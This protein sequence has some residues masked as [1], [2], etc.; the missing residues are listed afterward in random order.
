MKQGGI[1]LERSAI[2]TRSARCNN[3]QAQADSPASRSSI[4]IGSL[5]TRTPV[6]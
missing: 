2:A 6:A 4:M 5:R 1:G 3:I